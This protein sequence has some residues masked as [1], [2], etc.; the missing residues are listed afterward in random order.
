MEGQVFDDSTGAPLADTWVELVGHNRHTITGPT[1]AYHIELPQ[2]DSV[3]VRV[4][5]I[6]YFDQVFWV[7]PPELGG[8]RASVSLR[9]RPLKIYQDIF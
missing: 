3:E 5:G 8:I 2:A 4:L 7:H 6:G 9:P 1:G